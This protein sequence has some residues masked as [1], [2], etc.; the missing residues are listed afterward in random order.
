MQRLVNANASDRLAGALSQLGRLIK[1]LHILRYIQEEKLRDAIQ[2]Q[3]NRGEFRHILAKSLFFANWG[4]FR[5]GDY[6]EV[7][8]KA[9]CLS[10]LSNAVL[11]WNTVHIARIVDQ[12]RSAGH[13]VEDE[14]L[15]RVS[16]LVHAHVIPNGSYFQSPRRRSDAAPEPVMA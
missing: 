6:E 13:V 16:P 9:S 3:L 11:V 14:D 1:T 12:L 4:T 5:S 2:M 7:M 15:A 8:N 10:L